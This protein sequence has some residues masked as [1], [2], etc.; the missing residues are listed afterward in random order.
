MEKKT[1]IQRFIYG[2]KLYWNTPVKIIGIS[3]VTIG[4]IYFGFHL[5]VYSTIIKYIPTIISCL[6]TFS[7]VTFYLDDYILSK[8]FLIKYIQIFSFVCILL[9]PIFFYFILDNM[10]FVLYANNDDK[11]EINLHGHVSIDK[12]AAKALGNTIG[13]QIGLGASI[14]GIGTAVS[15]GIAKS[16]MP[17]LQKAA[18][19]VASG[20][21]TGLGHSAISNINRKNIWKEN[22]SNM[23]TDTINSN[24]S[25]NISKFM[26]NN[27]TSSPLENLLFDIEALNYICLSLVIILIMQILFKFFV[28]NNITLNFSSKLGININNKLEYYLNKIIILNKKMNNVYLWLI[29]LLL[30]IGLSISAYVSGD[31]Y[32]DL[33]TYINMHNSLKSNK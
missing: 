3:S 21:F 18:I 14:V 29:L 6:I 10:D 2:I 20:L 13:S 5:G 32:N 26:D 27:T 19:I 4:L 28:K 22:T 33:D 17:P 25:S 31:L 1:N 24:I 9:A 7:I 8:S 30:I 16:S 11:N 23:Y 12:D 15:K